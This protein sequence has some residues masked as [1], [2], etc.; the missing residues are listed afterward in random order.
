MATAETP[1][2]SADHWMRDIAKMA[3]GW[4]IGMLAGIVLLVWVLPTVMG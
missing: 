2:E 1:S 4:T 3:I